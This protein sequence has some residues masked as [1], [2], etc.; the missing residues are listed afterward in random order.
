MRKPI[1]TLDLSRSHAHC[2]FSTIIIVRKD[3]RFKFESYFQ[4][5]YDIPVKAYTKSSFSML[6]VGADL[7]GLPL[8]DSL[9]SKGTGKNYGIEMTIEKFFQ[10]TFLFFIYTYLFYQ[11]KYTGSDGVERT[12]AFDGGYVFNVLGGLEIPIGKGN[13]IISFRRENDLCRRRT[14]ILL[15]ICKPPSFKK[16]LVPI[17]N[18]AFHSAV[19]GLRTN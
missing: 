9:A 14:V 7:D 19:Q 10:Q 12:S 8:V 1:E 17:D 15:L 3:F 2:P 11:S 13:K 6:N 16:K 18:Q 5:L 4:Y